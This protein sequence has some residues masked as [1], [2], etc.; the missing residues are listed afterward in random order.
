MICITDLYNMRETRY[1]TLEDVKNSLGILTQFTGAFAME[2]ANEKMS[3]FMSDVVKNCGWSVPTITVSTYMDT[4]WQQYI[5]PKFFNL[6]ICMTEDSTIADD[7]AEKVFSNKVGSIIAWM[8]ASDEK[9][10]LLIKNQEDNKNNLLKAI[11]SASVTRFNDTPQNSGDFSDDAHT[12]NY[13]KVENETDGAS[14]LTRLNEVEDNLKRLYEDW[15][16]EF[17]KFIIWSE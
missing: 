1:F 16:N 8:R 9:F 15:S 11:K 13:T 17:R 10:S 5:Y 4:C 3:E 14:L 6:N 12:T 2:V 7:D